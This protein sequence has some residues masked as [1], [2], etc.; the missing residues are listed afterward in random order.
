[1]PSSAPNKIRQGNI[2]KQTQLSEQDW[3]A[4]ILA[5]LV[6]MIFCTDKN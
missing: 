4:L 5:M 2:L 3:D 1:M 6:E